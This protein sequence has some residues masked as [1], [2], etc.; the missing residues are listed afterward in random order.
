MKCIAAMDPYRV[1]GFKGKIPWK[2]SAEIKWFK[3]FTWN[4]TLIMGLTT[5]E[6]IPP[7][8]NRDIVVLTNSISGM[9]QQEF[10]EKHRHKCHKLFIRTDR[11]FDPQEFPNAIVAGGAKT[12]WNMLPYI[13]ELYMS[14]IIDQYE[15]DCFMPVFEYLFPHSAIHREYKDFW[16]VKYWK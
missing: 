6:N 16:V 2:I 3:E 4:N 7:L 8:R 5:F 1:I 14:Y 13:N 10:Y 11:T 15:G 12:Y 9:S